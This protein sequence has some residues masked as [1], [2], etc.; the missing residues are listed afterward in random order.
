MKKAPIQNFFSRKLLKEAFFYSVL[1][2]FMLNTV[3][4]SIH[5]SHIRSQSWYIYIEYGKTKD[6][7]CSIHTGILI[8][9]SS[10]DRVTQQMPC[11]SLICRICGD[12]A[13]GMNFNVITCISC[14]A[15]FRRNALRSQVSSYFHLKKFI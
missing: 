14:K 15:F 10:N 8:I 12:V 6:I 3:R 4:A 5:S 2:L 7:Y 13:R 11:P 1:S 9:M